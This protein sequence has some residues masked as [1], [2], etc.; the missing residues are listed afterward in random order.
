M[1]LMTIKDTYLL[2]LTLVGYTGTQLSADHS[3]TMSTEHGA[4]V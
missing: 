2:A 1:Y 3:D 4:W